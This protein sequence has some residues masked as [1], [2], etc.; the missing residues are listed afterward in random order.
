MRWVWDSTD[1]DNRVGSLTP[2]LAKLGGSM[3]NSR[4]LGRSN[5]FMNLGFHRIAMALTIAAAFGVW[6]CGGIPPSSH[7]REERIHEA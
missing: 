4:N 6:G 5:S 3:Q 7:S 1:L 2:T